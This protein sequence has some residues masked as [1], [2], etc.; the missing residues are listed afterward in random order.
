MI[1]IASDT[2]DATLPPLSPSTTVSPP[3]QPPRLSHS[4]YWIGFGLGWTGIYN[5]PPTRRN[6]P[7]HQHHQMPPP[8]LPPLPPAPTGVPPGTAPTGCGTAAARVRRRARRRR[9]RRPRRQGLRWQQQQQQRLG[10]GGGLGRHRWGWDLGNSRGLGHYRWAGASRKAGVFKAWLRYKTGGGGCCYPYLP[11]VRQATWE[12]RS[13]QAR[14]QHL[15]PRPTHPPPLPTHP[16]THPPTYPHP[17][18][19]TSAAVAGRRR[20][21]RRRG[22]V[23]V[24]DELTQQHECGGLAAVEVREVRNRGQVPVAASAAAGGGGGG[25]GVCRGGRKGRSKGQGRRAGRGCHMAGGGTA[26]HEA[27]IHTHPARHEAHTPRPPTSQVTQFVLRL[28][29]RATHAHPHPIRIHPVPLYHTL[30]HPAPAS[31]LIPL[32]APPLTG[33]RGAAAQVHDEAGGVLRPRPNQHLAV[34]LQGL[35]TPAD[36]GCG[37]VGG[38][39]SE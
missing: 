23:C 22:G 5:S 8:P 4:L 16:P 10:H 13:G 17:P 7:R 25:V 38:W 15:P 1:N 14:T 32:L 31:L 2:T 28:S 19:P 39:V 20:R 26:R 11:R 29:S 37:G 6:P 30:V 18:T 24:E 34:L 21:R 35:G 33:G 9:R 36:R 3:P 27:H 12:S